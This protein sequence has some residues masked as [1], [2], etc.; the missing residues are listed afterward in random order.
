MNDQQ[1]QHLASLCRSVSW[2]ADMAAH[3]TFRAG[4]VVEALVEIGSEEELS[5]LLQW[6]A[7][8]R[9]PWQVIGGGS[10]ILVATRRHGGVFIRLRN[11]VQGVRLVE[12]P[13]G[14]SDRIL[15]RVPAGC[16]LASVVGWC[17]R[18]GL[19]GLSS[20]AG[21]P[22]SIGGAVRMNAGAFGHSIGERVFSL[23]CMTA[24]GELCEIPR[25][26]IAFAYR[27]TRL[28]GE[29][30]TNKALVTA[31]VLALE[32]GDRRQIAEQCRQ[33]VDRRQQKQPRGVASAG[34]FFKNPAGDFAGRLIEK[35]G[36][37]GLAQGK[38]MV[39]PKHANFIV[40][41]GGAEPE[42]ILFLMEKV[43]EVVWRQSGVLLEPEVHIL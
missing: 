23:R 1:R 39:S 12:V 16:N 13:K 25:G 43:R 3:S 22:G 34:S 10:N 31:V 21:I 28:P 29:S 30:L 27:S 38:A 6:L 11:S 41:T 7:G 37:K 35:A 42:D 20:M 14:S 32:P 36:L 17:A 18:N 8:E 19:A 40:N 5:V 26:E 2:E 24:P 33:I 9:I 4:G 15:V